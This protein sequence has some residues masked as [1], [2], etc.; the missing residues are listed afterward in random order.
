M[1]YYSVQGPSAGN[2]DI[3]QLRT[4]PFE[5]TRTKAGT[6]NRLLC[7]LSSYYIL[8]YLCTYFVDN[9]STFSHSLCAHHDNV[10]LLHDKSI[11]EEGRRREEGE[12]GGSAGKGY[13]DGV[14]V[15]DRR[16]EGGREERGEEGIVGKGERKEQGNAQCICRVSWNL[17]TWLSH[18]HRPVVAFLMAC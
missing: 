9:S 10:H 13:K 15:G 1:L 2:V 16:E 18:A 6:A 11:G 4:A 3:T 5:G 12:E 8:S 17:T 7:R 14:E